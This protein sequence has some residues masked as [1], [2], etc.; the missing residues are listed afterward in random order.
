MKEKDNILRD[1]IISFWAWI[2]IWLVIMATIGYFIWWKWPWKFG[3]NWPMWNENTRWQF[4]SDRTGWNFDPSSMSDEQLERM[5]KRAW[6]TK[7]EL[8]KRIDSWE[9][10][11]DIMPAR[12]WSWSM[13]WT[14][15]WN[16]QKTWT[17][18]N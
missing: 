6:I 14:R 11:R 17:W 18:S 7:E 13:S 8:K 12:N 3:N 1:K 16:N 2:L 5:A 4:P 10:I 9:S 15:W